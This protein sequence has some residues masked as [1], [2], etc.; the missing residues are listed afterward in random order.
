MK[1]K[2]NQSSF[3]GLS[4]RSV[5]LFFL[6]VSVLL[7]LY[8]LK[9]IDLQVFLFT[10]VSIILFFLIYYIISY[11]QIH[12]IDRFQKLLE[13]LDIQ[14]NNDFE[15]RNSF[16]RSLIFPPDIRD[17]NFEVYSF[18]KP[19]SFLGGDLY[20]QSKDSKGKYWFAIG[21][22]SGHDVN[23]HLFSMMLI[24]G[25]SSLIH[26]CNTPKE[27]NEQ[28][29]YNLKLRSILNGHPLPC[30]A[31]LVVLKIDEVGK[32]EHYGQHPNLVVYRKQTNQTE[33]IETSGGFIGNENYPLPASSLQEPKGFQLNS[34]DI[35][36]V[37]TDGIFE[38]KNSKNQ[39]YGYRLYEFLL[40]HPKEDLELFLMNLYKEVLEFSRGKIQ[41]DLTV[42]VIRKL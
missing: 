24:S 11:K 17:E 1:R 35:L 14:E 19:F 3:S 15:A 22:A 2:H 28:L 13:F 4:R 23:S 41:D 34:G 29:N 26:T 21:D 42:M 8:L 12:K 39:Y 18:F 36:F 16:A 30:Y 9:K 33:V 27:I 37:F 32:V 31:S 6:F 10:L 38:Q 20:F 25:L 5:A 40:N 7:V